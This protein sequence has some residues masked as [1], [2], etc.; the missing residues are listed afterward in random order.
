MNAV[1][2][3]FPECTNLLCN[4]HIN[5]NV[6]AKC[7][8]LIAQKN[9]WDYFDECLKKFEIACAPWPMFVDYVKETWII[10]HKEKFVSAWTNKVMHLGNTTTNRVE[11]AHSSLKDCYKI[12]LKTYAVCGMP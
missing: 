3:V 5:K 7:K 1:K 4:F 2:D 11:S 6:K 12:T 10:P 8:S 9:A